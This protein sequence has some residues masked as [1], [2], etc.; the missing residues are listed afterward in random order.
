MD[1]PPT[2]ARLNGVRGGGESLP[3]LRGNPGSGLGVVAVFPVCLEA[4]LP[5]QL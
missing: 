5:P 3:L 2:T 4:P 1:S